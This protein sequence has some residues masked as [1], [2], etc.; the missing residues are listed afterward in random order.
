MPI[1]PPESITT[2]IAHRALHDGNQTRAENNLRAIDAAI[3][4][5]YG[6]EID[7]QL[8]HDGTAMVFHDY[9]LNRLTNETGPIAQRSWRELTQTCFVTGELGVPTLDEVLEHVQGRVPLLI[10]LKDQDGGMGQDIGRLE[11]AVASTFA[12]YRGPIALMSFNPH[13]VIRLAELCPDLPRGLTS[14]DF[15]T[16]NWMLLKPQTRA[17]LAQMPDYGRAD[18]SF[19]SYRWQELGAPRVSELKSDGAAIL[20][21]TVCSPDEERAARKIADNITFENF[22]PAPPPAQA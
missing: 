3:A 8:S 17:R 16:E 18:A 2:P 7:L 6:I 11:A 4:G 20:C 13:S 15:V 21:W 12:G 10:E 14:C 19:I 5:G 1:L 22:L 9:S